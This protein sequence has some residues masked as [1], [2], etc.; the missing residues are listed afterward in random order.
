MDFFDKI[1]HK[2]M[3]KWEVRRRISK[4]MQGL[5]LP[6]IVKEL[7]EKSR[8]LDLTVDRSDEHIAQVNCLGT[9]GFRHVVNLKDKT[10]TCC[11]W[12]LSGKPCVHTIALI[13]KMRGSIEQQV[14][15]YFSV[16]KF[17][18]AYAP[19]IHPL[20]DSKLWPKS[21]HG[22]MLHP[23]ILKPVAGRR[24]TERYKGCGEKKKKGSHQCP[25]CKQYGHRWH[26]CR[27]G[28]PDQ[29]A[30]MLLERYDQFVFKCCSPFGT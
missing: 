3:V 21:E 30:A 27:N 2:L 26:T 11:E 22:F 19:V 23:P 15:E 12:Q 4:K 10:C 1:Y 14:H 20:P 9:S 13:C 17:R 18:S 16:E 25:I 8:G 24:R 5:I 6:H 7:K 28:D 29:M